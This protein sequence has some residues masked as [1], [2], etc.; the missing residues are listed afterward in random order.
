M[1]ASQTDDTAIRVRLA[2]AYAA[3]GQ[4]EPALQEYQRVAVANPDDLGL[5]MSL[6]N[7]YHQAGRQPQALQE[8]QRI[9]Q[10][11]A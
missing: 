4:W 7:A 11:R 8:Y 2:D 9:T 1:R 3:S 10:T 5:Q 6:A